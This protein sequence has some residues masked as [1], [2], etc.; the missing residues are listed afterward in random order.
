[1]ADSSIIG[2]T[3]AYFVAGEL[4][5][6]NLIALLTTRN[7]AGIDIIVTNPTTY[8]ST[9]IQVKTTQRNPPWLLSKKDEKSHG[10]NLFYVFVDMTNK[11]IE[12]YI[13]P[14][15]IVSKRVKER[16]QRWLKGKSTRVD[17]VMRKFILLESDKANYLNKW[18]SL[19]I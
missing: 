6:R 10:K 16:H 8:K 3:G 5:K 17:G 7:T 15:N 9:N 12:Y 18:D 4:S 1:M 19:G 14:S 2:A 11:K 13:I